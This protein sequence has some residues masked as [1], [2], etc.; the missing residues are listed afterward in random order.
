MTEHLL[1][2]ATGVEHIVHPS[3]VGI[4]RIP[5]RYYRNKLACE[6]LIEA[7]GLPYTIVRA[8]QFHELIAFGLHTAGRWPIAPLPLD[9]QFQPV[10]SA[11]VANRVAELSEHAPTG[12]APDFGCPEVLTLEQLIDRLAHNA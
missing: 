6:R 10:A 7:S 1:A 12:R 8:T 5:F 3:I 11:E 9:F 4:D 2:A